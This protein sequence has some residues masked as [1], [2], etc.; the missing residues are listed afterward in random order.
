MPVKNEADLLPEVISHVKALVD[1][2]IVYEGNSVDDTYNLVKECATHIMRQA[3]DP[4]Y[5]LN[6]ARYSYHYMLEIIKKNYDYNRD[7]V[8]GVI[9]MGDRFFLNKTPRK[10]VEDAENEGFVS[11]EGI[12]TEFLRCRADPWTEENDTFPE[13]SKSLRHL[14]RWTRYYE[15]QIFAFKITDS[16]DYRMSSYPWPKGI[17]RSPQYF[18]QFTAD[19]PFHEH[20]GKRSPNALMW[21]YR[22]G[23]VGTSY[24]HNHSYESFESVVNTFKG[25]YRSNSCIPWLGMESLYQ[26]VE[27]KNKRMGKKEQQVYFDSI[28]ENFINV[29]HRRLPERVDIRGR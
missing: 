15:R 23:S 24:K 2:I 13:Y 1:D 22:N 11:V 14:C 18:K 25:F 4:Q 3:D 29:Q 28:E 7:D 8:W 12:K 6:M 21:R 27:M 10:I 16:I 19:M 5:N 17:G 9:T 26:I 20:Q